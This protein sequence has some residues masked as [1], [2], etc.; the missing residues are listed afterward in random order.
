[1]VNAMYMNRNKQ[2][3]KETSMPMKTFNNA[4]FK[5][6]FHRSTQSSKVINHL[7]IVCIISLI[8]IEV[9]VLKKPYNINTTDSKESRNVNRLWLR[10]EYDTCDTDIWKTPG[11]RNGKWCARALS[12]AHK[13]SFA[14]WKTEK[15]FT[16]PF[17]FCV[18][19]KKK[20][21]I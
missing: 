21:W 11:Y 20:A 3:K 15:A 7:R 9:K 1:M 17:I 18:R 2:T 10:K 14:N 13:K 4:S 5:R 6:A 16:E 8:N 19:N 12:Y